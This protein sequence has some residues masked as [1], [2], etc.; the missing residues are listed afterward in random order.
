MVSDMTS[1]RNWVLG[2]VA[3]AMVLVVGGWFL[4][5]SPKRAEVA[6]LQVQ[7]EAV[8]AANSQKATEVE[9]LKQQNKDLPEKQAE[10]AALETKI[11]T[12]PDMPA[13]IQEL[14]DIATN[15]GVT[16]TGMTPAAAVTVGQGSAAQTGAALTPDALAAVNV[17]LTLVGPY[18]AI[19]K[20]VNDLES[21]DRYTLNT[22]LTIVDDEEAEATGGGKATDLTATVNARVFYV[23]QAVEIDATTTTVPAPAP[24][25]AP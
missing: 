25:T 14:Q 22:G 9:L 19:Q 5:I 20:F 3:A 6:D 15:A 10:L 21:S 16:L 17:D 7:T 11:P 23:P 24:T 8:Q 18:E 2:A 13:Y 1:T 4:L 12:A